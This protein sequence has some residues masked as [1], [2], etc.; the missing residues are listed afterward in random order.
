MKFFVPVEYEWS[1]GGFIALDW[2]DDENPLNGYW[3][4]E[5]VMEGGK[6]T[7][8]EIIRA[9]RE[10]NVLRFTE[11][12]ISAAMMRIKEH[13]RRNIERLFGYNNKIKVK[14]R[15]KNENTCKSNA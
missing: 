2:N 13:Q 5:G 11:I 12:S 14:V 3:S 15:K 7:K 4:C 6:W 8:K 1:R 10:E 9:C